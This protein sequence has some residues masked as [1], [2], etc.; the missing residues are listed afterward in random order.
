VSRRWFVGAIVALGLLF[1]LVVVWSWHAP[2]GDGLQYHALASE[3]S[4]HG[5]FALG[6]PPRPL[7]YVRMPGYPLFLAY[8]A[9]RKPL[10]LERHLIRATRANV[11]LDLATALCVFAVLSRFG[12]RAALIGLV[13]TFLSPLMFLLSCY[14]LTETLATSL[15]TVEVWLAL[16]AR[17][18]R[19]FLHA[20]LCGLV[21]GLAQLVRNDAVTVAPAVA[22]AIY[23]SAEPLRRRAAALALAA[24][25][26]VAVFAPWPLRNL[27]QFAAPHFGGTFW[28]DN[29]G[30]P[31][32][33]EIIDWERTWA[34]SAPG[35]SYLDVPIVFGGPLDPN[36]P[37]IILP[38][39]YDSPEERARIAELFTRYN[40]EHLSPAVNAGF[41]Q[42]A[43]ERRRAH[44]L[45]TFVWLPLQRIV[46]LFSPVP[47]WELP[48][49]S[50]L[51]GLPKLRPLF[52][53]W[54]KLVY[55]LGLVGAVVMWRRDRRLLVILG[56]WVAARAVL[57]S[58]TI[59]NA[60]TERYLVECYPALIM[61][62][63]LGADWIAARV[64][65]RA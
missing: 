65:R 64:G 33:T 36:R 11:L 50:R 17:R 28:R 4:A 22:L 58:W 16:R 21:A 1:R 5:R 39:M 48:M 20:A 57:F 6:P 2:A 12:R 27:R 55:A 23:W 10:D 9:V 29:N 24:I 31:L 45:R 43:Q 52:G 7:T 35:E 15:A 19:L 51:L 34:T 13:A 42:L 63:A 26:A 54:D 30:T 47:E 46:H 62:A 56:S 38:A 41:A 60:T 25:I 32:P 40:K 49:R 3:L 14:G 44:P 61:F 18:E 53:W 8:V 37:G 59:P